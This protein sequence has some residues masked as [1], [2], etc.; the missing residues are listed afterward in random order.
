MAI[1]LPR[2]ASVAVGG[3]YP[4]T[5]LKAA[6]AEHQRW[7][8]VLRGGVN[9]AVEKKAGKKAEAVRVK[10]NQER[11][12]LAKI[13]P[14]DGSSEKTVVWPEGSFGAIQQK[15][16]EKWS[17]KKSPR[18]QNQVVSRFKTDILPKLGHLHIMD[19]E[20][21]DIANMAQAIDSRGAG[22]LA[23]RAL[24]ATGQVFRFAIAHG[25]V[26][27]NS[28]ADFKPGDVLKEQTVTHHARISQRELSALLLAMENDTGTEIT[29]YAM[30]IM[31]RTFVRT[32]E[33]REAPWV[34]LDLDGGWWEIPKKRMKMD[35]PHI[36]PLSRQVIE[37]LQKLKEI[38]GDSEY[39]FPG[40][41]DRKKCMSNNTILNSLKRMGYHGAMTGHGY[42][43]LASTILHEGAKVSPLL[44]TG[45]Y[46]HEWI[47]LQLAH[48]SR[49]EVSAAYN[50]AK[51]LDGRKRMMQ[52]WSDFLDEQ[53]DKAKQAA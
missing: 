7:Q 47:E 19:I 23:R 52:D 45:G 33:L 14:V 35:S 5:S 22:E 53:L 10:L 51:Y 25:L 41:F 42:R 38:T 26:R 24:F 15:W 39:V 43:G 21:P 9:P 49:D 11:S 17:D 2:E 46:P 29:W 28:A 4:L 40:A 37:A 44:Q 8:V 50:Y 31:A 34:E 32:T 30:Q 12:T 3:Q 6:R 48:M 36:V 27:R 1:P 16:F 18:Y 20:A 13:E